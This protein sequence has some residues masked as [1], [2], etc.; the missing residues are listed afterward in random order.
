MISQAIYDS[1][2]LPN[3]AIEELK[4]ILLYRDLVWQLVRRDVL[5]R[6]K[7]SFLGVLWTMLNPLGTMIILTLVFSQIFHQ[8]DNY[9]LH[10]LTGLLVWNFFTQTT[11][12]AIKAFI[13]GGDLLKRIYVP[14][15]IFAISAIGTGI[16]NMVLSIVPLVVLMM[17]SSMPVTWTLLLLPL[18]ILLLSIFSLGVGLLLSNWAIYFADVIEMYQI[19]L[20]AWMYLTP[21]IYPLEFLPDSVQGWIIYNP[22]TP[23]LTVFRLLVEGSLPSAADWLTATLIALAALLAGWVTFAKNAQDFSASA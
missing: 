5:T 15:T 7:R 8:Q 14:R 11:N 18:P 3:P 10:V 19:V 20:V 21:I 4:G 17:F 23:L 2:N 12:A 6:Y 16:V 1:A 13:W 22:V 9:H